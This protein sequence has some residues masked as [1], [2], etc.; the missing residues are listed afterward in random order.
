[1]SENLFSKEKFSVLTSSSKA[2]YLPGTPIYTGE[3]TTPSKV[4]IYHYKQGQI[5]ESHSISI[6]DLSKEVL[7]VPPGEYLWVNIIGLSEIEHYQAF[8]KV[9]GIHSLYLE[10]ILNVNQRPRLILEPNEL[11]IIIKD[12][13]LNKNFTVSHNQ[14]A[15]YLTE[16]LVVTMFE[17]ESALIRKLDTTI[18][19]FLSQT[20]KPGPDLIVAVLLDQVVDQYFVMLEELED[21]IDELEDETIYNPSPA[22]LEK[23]QFLKKQTLLI[24]RILFATKENFLR[25]QRLKPKL[26]QETTRVYFDDVLDHLIELF[27]GIESLRELLI[28]LI[29]LYMSSISN[30]SNDVMM[31]LTIIATIFIPHTFLVGVYGM[32]FRYMPELSWKWSYFI[33]W[34]FLILLTFLEIWIFK[35]KGWLNS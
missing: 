25:M 13:G 11:V 17:K 9:I 14:V 1:M 4:S 10:D 2:G 22:S 6:Q 8:A 5:L 34:I 3:E 31:L 12:I 33:L 27:E 15:I 16:N 32:N 30:K 35:K 18:S 23:I 24:K 21:I 20:S 26:I 28:G 19:T 29:D 7:K